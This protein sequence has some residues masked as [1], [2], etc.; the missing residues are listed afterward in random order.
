MISRD[1]AITLIKK[2]LK[3]EENIKHAL[4]LEII[5]REMAKRLNRDINQWGL[6]GL[7]HNIDYEYCQ[8][9]PAKIGMLSS[10]ILEGLLPE[11]SVNAIKANNY[12][13]TD[14][15]PITTLDKSIIASDAI[16]KL[17]TKSTYKMPSKKINELEINTLTNNFYDEKFAPRISRSRIKLCEDIGI[18]TKTYL[19]F[20]LTILK[21]HAERI[22]I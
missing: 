19:S 14:V 15:I 22:G 21:N 16:I 2:Y 20:V 18:E 12:M 6:T 9:D 10:Q 4:C 5:L 8:G 13:H 1:E 11:K 3:Q 7:L 17:I